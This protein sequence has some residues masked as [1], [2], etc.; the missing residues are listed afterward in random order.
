MLYNFP[1]YLYLAVKQKISSL[2]QG[3][4][5][6]YI[7][8]LDQWLAHSSSSITVSEWQVVKLPHFTVENQ[9]V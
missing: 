8:W 5:C 4:L 2:G 3:F 1:I 7:E 9:T 6:V